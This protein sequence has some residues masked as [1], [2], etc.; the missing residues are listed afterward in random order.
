MH[1]TMVSAG[2]DHT[3]LL[4]SDGRAVAVGQHVEGQCNLPELETGVEFVQVSAGGGHTVLL[5]SDGRVVA[6]GRNDDGQCNI[7]NVYGHRSLR[8]WLLRQPR[9][10]MVYKPDLGEH[11]II[12]ERRLVQLQYFAG[13]GA[14]GMTLVAEDMAGEEVARLT[15]ERTLCV[16]A[17]F[18]RLASTLS[19][20]QA[21]LSV[22][23]PH[24][25][26]LERCDPRALIAQMCVRDQDSLPSAFA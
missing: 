10:W 24:G 15:V 26:L 8:Q 13:D 14:E 17:L 23:L 12:T 7:P 4:R 9:L 22:L 25:R 20:R 16:D 5:R 3:V 18:A 21:K 6:V 11:R 1:P 19:V 2:V